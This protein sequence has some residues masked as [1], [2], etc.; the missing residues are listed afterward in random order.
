MATNPEYVTVNGENQ[1]YRT[2]ISM[3]TVVRPAEDPFFTV[4]RTQISQSAFVQMEGAPYLAG[5]ANGA[6]SQVGIF[7]RNESD[8]S[9]KVRLS[10]NDELSPNPSRVKILLTD[11]GI[12]VRYAML[13][14]EEDQEARGLF[15]ERLGNREAFA[16]D[17]D[18]P[19]DKVQKGQQLLQERWGIT[20]QMSTRKVDVLATAKSLMESP[21]SSGV[22]S[23]GMIKFK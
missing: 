13:G 11:Q 1:E 6:Y 16:W 20:P 4:N 7:S 15:G 19:A 9:L 8:K 22:F 5:K 18:P 3:S 21:S 12:Q 10:L 2:S 23:P 17:W 14:G